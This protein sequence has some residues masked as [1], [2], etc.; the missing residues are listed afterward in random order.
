MG[1]F[2]E[3]EIEWYPHRVDESE[4]DRESHS[5]HPRR[6]KLPHEVPR[7]V[8]ANAVWF[9][10]INCD[11]PEKPQLCGVGGQTNPAPLVLEAARFY[12]E[13]D[14]PRWFIHCFLLMPDHLHAVLSFPRN[15]DLR[16]VITSW[17]GY[18]RRHHGIEWQSDFFDHRLRSAGERR[19]K[20]DYVRCNPVRKGLCE[21]PEDWRYVL[22]FDPHTGEEL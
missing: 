12:H 20:I 9:I 10:T 4:R 11:P 7:W 17:K 18:V 1:W 14:D 22:S 15:G 6:K 2:L 16:N 3:S 13:M 5:R 21:R 8:P 19:Q